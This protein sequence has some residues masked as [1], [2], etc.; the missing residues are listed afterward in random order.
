MDEK[1]KPLSGMELMASNLLRALGLDPVKLTAEFNTRIEQ[2]EAG[3]KA[4]NAALA[5][6][7]VRLDTIEAQQAKIL[8]LL[9]QEKAASVREPEHKSDGAAAGA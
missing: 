4:L 7:N 3:I 6:I 2:F 1:A 9:E 5:A 8:S